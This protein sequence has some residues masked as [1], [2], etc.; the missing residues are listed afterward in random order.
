MTREHVGF[1]GLGAMGSG[2]A[3]NLV[4]AGFATR[5]YNRTP[6]RARPLVD[7][8]AEAAD[9]PAEAAEPGGVVVTMVADDAALRAVTLGVGGF[10]DRLGAGGVHLSMSTVAPATSDE[11]AEEH[12]RRGS[13]FVAAPVFGRPE[14]AAARKLWIC[15]SGDAGGRARVRPL[16]DAMGQGVFDFGDRPGAA[17]VVKLCGNFMIASAIEAMAEAAHL[18]ERSGVDAAT[19]L[20]LFGRTLFAC[21]IYQNYGKIIA[22][23][24]FTPPGFE[25]SLGLKDMRLVGEA[26]DAAG[27]ALPAARL[28]RERFADAVARGRGELDWT[29][30]ALGLADEDA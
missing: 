23:R 30:V 26:A 20:D 27:V 29:A 22:E 21:P 19:V 7:A 17:N 5:V 8:G 2:M 4:G 10:A 15:A 12:A 6:E 14:A 3:A 25:L 13:A 9:S 24:R 16:L 1:V 18:A 28:L 11:L